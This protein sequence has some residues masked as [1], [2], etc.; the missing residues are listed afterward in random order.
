MESVTTI[1]KKQ[2]YD[3]AWANK[4]WEEGWAY[5]KT[6]VDTVYEPFLILDKNLCVLAANRSFYRLFRTKAQDVEHKYIKDLKKGEWNVPAI[7]ALFKV[8]V[9]RNIFFNGFEVSHRFPSMGKKIM[10]LNGKRLY[11]NDE[12]SDIFPPI[13]LFAMTDVME[14][15]AIAEA[16][17]YYATEIEKKV[18]RRTKNLETRIGQLKKEVDILKIDP[19]Y[20]L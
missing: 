4:I 10:V 1:V 8:I 20:L 2:P 7:E 9:P 11:K 3:T 14:M 17:E 15:T 6:L 19:R 18:I 13:I 5:I 16:L 12:I